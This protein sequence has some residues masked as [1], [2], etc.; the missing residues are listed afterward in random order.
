MVDVDSTKGFFFLQIPKT[1]MCPLRRARLYLKLTNFHFH[2][3]N[4]TDDSHNSPKKC[5]LNT[6]TPGVVD[7]IIMTASDLLVMAIL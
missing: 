3:E 5:D 1:P 2:S 6:H 7:R 4:D